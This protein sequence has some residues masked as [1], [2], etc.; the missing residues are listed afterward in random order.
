MEFQLYREN[1][2]KIAPYSRQTSI[3]RH[4]LY[5]VTLGCCA[6]G[7]HKILPLNV[8][9]ILRFDRKGIRHFLVR[10]SAIWHSAVWFDVLSIRPFVLAPGSIQLSAI[11]L[12]VTTRIPV[13]CTYLLQIFYLFIQ[14]VFYTWR[15]NTYNFILEFYFK[16]YIPTCMYC[17]YSRKFPKHFVSNIILTLKGLIALECSWNN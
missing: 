16:F 17:I 8:V 3:I 14:I 15:Q 2:T 11:L 9:E 10:H 6:I 12:S 5:S 4:L 1:K 13:M 7:D